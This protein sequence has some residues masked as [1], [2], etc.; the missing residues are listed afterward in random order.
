MLK[1]IKNIIAILALFFSTQGIADMRI[2][3]TA[4]NFSEIVVLLG[5]EAQLVG[6]DTT[7]MRPKNI[8]EPLPKIGY[9]RQLSAEG[10]LSLNPSLVLLATDAGPESV[11]K[12][13]E[14][15]KLNLLYLEEEQSL[16]GIKKNIQE[17]AQALQKDPSALLMEINKD[18][19]KLQS[20]LNKI[21]NK[22]SVLILLDTGT[23]GIYG[24]GK[25]SAGDNL[26]KI[27]HLENTFQENGHKPYAHEALA[28]TTAPIIL[29]ARREDA[30]EEFII[31]P[32][33]T[34]PANLTTLEITPAWR[35]KCV[36][37]LNILSGLGFGAYTA[38]DA[39]TILN[40]IQHCL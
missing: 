5:E 4:G 1:N 28:S 9:R 20:A 6:V 12:Q 29:I 22:K 36:F 25:N 18:E 3:S 26:L 32:F 15:A 14:N 34:L 33:D 8:M 23:Q 31:K 10:I 40:T 35:N 21:K 7:S 24:L 38:R 16:E 19:E 11:I 37:S 2:I 17:I 39:L 30:Q 13:L 27:L